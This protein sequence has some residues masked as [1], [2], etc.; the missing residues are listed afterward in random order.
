MP[1]I[2][3]FIS[4][5]DIIKYNLEEINQAG[6]KISNIKIP[7]GIPTYHQNARDWTVDKERDIYLRQVTTNQGR[8]DMGFENDGWEGWTLYY[9]GE[10]VWFAKNLVG[11]HGKRCSAQHHDYE[12]KLLTTS[13]KLININEDEI[14]EVIK[15]AFISY[16]DF[17]IYSNATEFT[18]TFTF[19][20]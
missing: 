10:L 6:Y 8:P 15:Q 19:T 16:K 12:I 11:G 5:A 18:A 13:L 2:N 9:K 4:E 17:G 20:E 7:V 3:E 1:F 14:K